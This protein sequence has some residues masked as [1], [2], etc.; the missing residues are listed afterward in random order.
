MNPV[1]DLVEIT[2]SSGTPIN[3]LYETFERKTA[4]YVA[5]DKKLGKVVCEAS[6]FIQQKR[7]LTVMSYYVKNK[8]KEDY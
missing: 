7:A 3:L 8:C 1:R 6:P 4:D 2:L 5:R